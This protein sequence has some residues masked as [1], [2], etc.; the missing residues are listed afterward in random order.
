LAKVYSSL[1]TRP[2]DNWKLERVS[3]I[4][5][6]AEE[7]GNCSLSDVISIKEYTCHVYVM[8][9]SMRS[10][11]G[12]HAPNVDVSIIR[13]FHGEHPLAIAVMP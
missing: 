4:S 8:L 3:G 7:Y 1:G 12:D 6:V 10:S 5:A 9:L 2:W 11:I 13:E